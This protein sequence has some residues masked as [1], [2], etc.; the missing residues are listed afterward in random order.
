MYT[1]LN[2]YRIDQW[3]I[4]GIKEGLEIYNNPSSIYENERKQLED[5]N[6]DIE[7]NL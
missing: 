6:K 2:C 4:P 1:I 7:S 5:I 3:L